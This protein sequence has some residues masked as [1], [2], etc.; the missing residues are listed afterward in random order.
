MTGT[1]R[2][3]TKTEI[4]I[5]LSLCCGSRYMLKRHNMHVMRHESKKKIVGYICIHLQF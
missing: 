5:N 4:L 1:D 2:K 3:Y